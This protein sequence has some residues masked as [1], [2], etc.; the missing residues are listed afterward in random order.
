MMTFLILAGILA[1][2]IA[3]MRIATPEYYSPKCCM[4]LAH[5][6]IRDHDAAGKCAAENE[7]GETCR[8]AAEA[9]GLPHLRRYSDDDGRVPA[10]AGK[11]TAR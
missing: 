4:G 9:S 6:I 2:G 1:V 3:A 11:H 8:E 5:R 7:A 10:N